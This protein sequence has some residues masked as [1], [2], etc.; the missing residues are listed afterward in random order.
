MPA[1][2][3]D[4]VIDD[5]GRVER[6]P[7]ELCVL[8]TLR[9]A[10]R[11]REVWVL[12]ATRWR[13]PEADLPT[14]FEANRDVHYEALRHPRDPDHFITALKPATSAPSISSTPP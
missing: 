6:V 3:Q 9:D 11:R 14:D 1:A 12:G 2:W 4:A 10:V 8:K 5:D 7:Y 13:N